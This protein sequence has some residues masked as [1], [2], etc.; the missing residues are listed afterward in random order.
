MKCIKCGASEMTGRH[1]MC[2]KCLERARNDES[3]A[4]IRV[5]DAHMRDRERN[6]G[7]DA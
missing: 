4:R 3:W 1:I 2:E 7:A 6:A 5:I